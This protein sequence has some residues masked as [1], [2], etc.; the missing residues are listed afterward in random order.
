[1]ILRFSLSR[2]DIH[3]Y[4]TILKNAVGSYR[5]QIGSS[6]T[7][8]HKHMIVKQGRERLFQIYD[9]FLLDNCSGEDTVAMKRRMVKELWKKLGAQLYAL[10]QLDMHNAC[11]QEGIA[12]PSI[13]Y[14]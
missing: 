1:M 14:E 7:K 2:H 12:F 4:E 9:E 3:Q 5:Y 8:E 11:Y 6:Y 10:D 13:I